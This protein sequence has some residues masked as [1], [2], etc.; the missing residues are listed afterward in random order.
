MGMYRGM[1]VAVYPD[2]VLPVLWIVPM[3]AI[4]REN[5]SPSQANSTSGLSLGM[6]HSEPTA[7]PDVGINEALHEKSRKK[8]SS[9]R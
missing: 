8:S 9:E 7:Q 1:L 4:V 5:Y 3:S 6:N 2:R